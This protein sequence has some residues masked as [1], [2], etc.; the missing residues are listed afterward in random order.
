MDSS[1]SGIFPV[2]SRINH[3]CI[4]NCNFVFNEDTGEQVVIAVRDIGSN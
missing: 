1:T 4:P 3:S 2:M